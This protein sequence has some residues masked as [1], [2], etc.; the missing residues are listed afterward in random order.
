MAGTGFLK[1]GPEWKS[2][3]DLRNRHV[4][5]LEQIEYGSVGTVHVK[6]KSYLIINKVDFVRVAEVFRNVG[7]L[8]ESIRILETAIE[9]FRERQDESSLK[10]IAQTIE[11]AKRSIAFFKKECGVG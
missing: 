9:I 4:E 3:E 6:H 11:S 5:N 8:D 1:S 7:L 10:M 2:F